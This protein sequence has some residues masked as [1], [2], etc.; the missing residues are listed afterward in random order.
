ML[1]LP[2]STAH[3]FAGQSLLSSWYQV[4][5]LK[6]ILDVRSKV[7]KETAQSAR[8]TWLW[9]G[10]IVSVFLSCNSG[11]AM[12]ASGAK[13]G[14]AEVNKGRLYYEV[15]GEGHPMVLIHGGGADSRMWDDQFKAF[16]EH[17]RV[18]RYD[19]R[20]AGKSELPKE[21]WSESQDLYRLL[22]FLNVE[23]V[24]VI[25]L[26]RGGW[27]SADFTLEHPEMVDAL[28]LTSSN[29]DGPPEAYGTAHVRE[30]AKNE[31]LSRAIDAAMENPYQNPPKENETARQKMRQM[32]EDS[33]VFNLL[34]SGDIHYLQR[35]KLP[36][37]PRVSAIK[38]PTL[39]IAGQ[40]DAPA[41]RAN[42]DRESKMI[43]GARLVVIPGGAHFIPMERPDDY[44]R[45][46]LE[47][48]GKLKKQ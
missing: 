41:A 33:A 19:Q 47:F 40:R 18:I 37:T 15:M 24:Y 31:G 39:L 43:P 30:I 26:S 13:S 23:K 14:M 9:F 36:P 1:A 45:S 32:R 42:Y 6:Q 21:P 4:K 7:M 16:A 48:L 34:L 8:S 11:N 20:G 27:I 12:Q 29:L 38:V 5:S 17:Y 44:N 3:F 10:I 2:E 25:G 35:R 46:V 28:I 22:K